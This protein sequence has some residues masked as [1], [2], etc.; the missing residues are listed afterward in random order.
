MKVLSRSFDHNG[1]IPEEFAFAR[2]DAANHFALSHNRNPALAWDGVPQ[3]A[4]GR[5]GF[6]FGQYSRRETR[7]PAMF[8]F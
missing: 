5:R 8:G 4:A 3:A 7:V 2:P 6:S 1:V